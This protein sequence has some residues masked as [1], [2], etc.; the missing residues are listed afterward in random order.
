[1]P[2]D[3]IERVLD[4]GYGY[5]QH[6]S[7]FA[8]RGLEVV[9]VTAHLSEASRAEARSAGF[10]PVETDMHFLDLPDA[11]FDMVWSHHS[12]EHSFSPMLALYEW[13]RVLRPGGWL[14]VTVPPHK[15]KV[16]SGHF[17][18]GWTIG[19]LMYMLGVMGYELDTGTFLRE[20]YNVRALVKRPMEPVDPRGLSWLHNLKDRLPQSIVRAAE[21]HHWSPGK[22]QFEGDLKRVTADEIVTR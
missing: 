8:G 11:S 12:L 5:G 13:M 14:C 1:L 3:E 10:E 21:E 20:G 2:Y 15:T 17:T 18:T 7:Y 4:V 22:F 16:V 9:G 6:A 19:Q